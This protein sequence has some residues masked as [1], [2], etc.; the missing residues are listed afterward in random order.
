VLNRV[1]LQLPEE[2]SG[3][4]THATLG[5]AVDAASPGETIGVFAHTHENTVIGA[6][7][8]PSEGKDLTITQC[9]VAKIDASAPADPY[10]PALHIMPTAG[11][12]VVIGL[13]FL[14]STGAEGLRVDGSGHDLRAL[15]A[16]GNLVG[17]SINGSSNRISFNGVEANLTGVRLAGTG[18]NVRGTI[19]GNLGHGIEITGTTNTVRA[20]SANANGAD[21]IVVSGVANV[22]RENQANFNSGDGIRITGSLNAIEA[23]TAQGNLGDGIH[24]TGNGNGDNT[25]VEFV[26]N[27]VTSNAG[28]GIKIEGR[29]HQLRTNESGDT[30]GGR[31][32]NG[33]CEYEVVSGNLDGGGNRANRDLV[34]P[35]T[36]GAPFPA[37]C[38]GTPPAQ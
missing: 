18:N 34:Q 32:D 26:D 16:T 9:T 37:G 11:S 4:T 24:A 21:G 5:A 30:A 6:Q 7:G 15:R 29:G 3:G 28:A 27:T 35:N 8:S 20:V 14:N 19:S 13:D 10:R 1:V 38:T 23:N 33:G 36:S 31:R 17:V 2:P 22:V 25:P 12:L